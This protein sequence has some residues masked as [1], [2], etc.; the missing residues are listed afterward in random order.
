[1][2]HRSQRGNAPQW[3]L[4]NHLNPNLPDPN[5]PKPGPEGGHAKPVPAWPH[6]LD[7]RRARQARQAA[8]LSARVARAAPDAVVAIQ[9][10]ALV[11][12]GVF[13]SLGEARPRSAAELKEAA[14]HYDRAAALE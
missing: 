4:G 11:L 10:R 5:D 13:G 3:G 7:T 12:S 6:A 14:T 9:M 1:M 2:T 8:A